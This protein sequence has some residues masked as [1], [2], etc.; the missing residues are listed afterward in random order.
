MCKTREKKEGELKL[1][2]ELKGRIRSEGTWIEAL[3][4]EATESVADAMLPGG[5]WAIAG[6]R[7]LFEEKDK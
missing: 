1:R 4:T 6:E 5:R 2:R 3:A 7:A